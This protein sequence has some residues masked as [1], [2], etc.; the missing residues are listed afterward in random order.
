MLAQ[1]AHAC[2]PAALPTLETLDFVDVVHLEDLEMGVGLGD[3]GAGG[4]KDNE[5]RTQS[6]ECGTK[7]VQ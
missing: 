2:Q 5:R 1:R 3:G 6:A 4:E 7:K